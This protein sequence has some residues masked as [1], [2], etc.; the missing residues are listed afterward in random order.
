MTEIKPYNVYQANNSIVVALSTGHKLPYIPDHV[1][2]Q[3]S[4]VGVDITDPKS[5]DLWEDAVLCWNVLDQNHE[6][7]HP[8][9][10]RELSKQEGFVP[11]DHATG[12]LRAL[13]SLLKFA[14]DK[15][16]EEQI[17]ETELKMVENKHLGSS[18]ESFLE[19]E[20]ISKQVEAGAIEKIAQL[21][22]EQL[23]DSVGHF[24]WDFGQKFFVETPHGNFVWSDPDYKGDNSFTK[25]DGLYKDWIK[26]IGISYGRDK[27]KH[28]IRSYCGDQIVLK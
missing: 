12:N 4:G 8:S 25:F 6:F 27:G 20:G 16:Y 21:D 24:S 19:E 5:Y 11:F 7:H 17:F 28:I 13:L 14:Q 23:L 18:F 22:R 15:L 26:Q 9:N 3:A 10:M 1:A 2:S